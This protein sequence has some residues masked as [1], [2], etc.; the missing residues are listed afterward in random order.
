MRFILPGL[1][2]L[3]NLR[4]VVQWCTQTSG[5]KSLFGGAGIQ[6]ILY[7]APEDQGI[8]KKFVQNERERMGL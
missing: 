4:G 2:K 1:S 5:E 3:L 6:F 8:I 7:S